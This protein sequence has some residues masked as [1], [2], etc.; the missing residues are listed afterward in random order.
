MKKKFDHDTFAKV[1]GIV[2][3]LALMALITGCAAKPKKTE[4]P[5]P[6]A[7]IKNAKNIGEVLGCMLGGCGKQPK[8]NQ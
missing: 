1:L 3:F 4:K 5:E 6:F 8:D 2:V 7:V